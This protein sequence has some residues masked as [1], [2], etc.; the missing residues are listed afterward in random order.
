MFTSKDA[1]NKI[2]SLSIPNNWNLEYLVLLPNLLWLGFIFLIWDAQ[3]RK[4]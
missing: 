1:P 4:F 3:N 2:G